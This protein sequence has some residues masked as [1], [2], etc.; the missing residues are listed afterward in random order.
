M[1]S[2]PRRA[3]FASQQRLIDAL[4]ADNAR[5]RAQL[6]PPPVKIALK[7]AAYNA[8]IIP[9]RLRRWCLD[10]KVEAEQV[11]SQWFVSEQSLADRMR[12]LNSTGSRSH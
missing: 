7:V 11:G 12:S 10:G 9:E 2:N 6:A 3:S 1:T 8:G 5:L 4:R